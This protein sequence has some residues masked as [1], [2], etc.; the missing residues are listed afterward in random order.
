MILG[1]SVLLAVAGIGGFSADARRTLETRIRES[2]DAVESTGEVAG[3]VTFAGP[4][5]FFLQDG[6]EALKVVT[7][8]ELLPGVGTTVAVKGVAELE[9]ARVVLSAREWRTLA[10]AALPPPK[11][12]LAADLIDPAAA[13]SPSGVNWRRVEVEGRAVEL[14]ES[15]FGIDVGGV[16]VSVAL[17][18]LPDFLA[19][20]GVTRPLVRVRGVAELLLDQSALFGREAYVIGVRISAASPD[21][22]TLV[23]D[24]VYLANVRD[25]RLRWAFGVLLG[26]LAAGVVAFAVV[27]FRQRRRHF[28]TATLMAERK[29]MADDIHD[30]IEQHLVGAGM[31]I[32]LK[33]GKEAQDVLIRAKQELRDIIW[34]LKND[35]ML[36]LKPAE[37][38]AAAARSCAREGILEVDTRL[39]A[40][41]P[42]LG[43][44]ALRDL[45]L[46][47]REAIGNALK[48][49]GARRV[50][51]F[52]E[53]RAHGI[54]R[55]VVVNDGEVF[56]P[57]AAPGAEAGHFGLEGMRERARRLGARLTIREV[58]GR[59][60]VAVEGAG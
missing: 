31:L 43:A 56:D 7:D 32:Q 26:L 17:G 28:R 53:S 58:D 35:D 24:L 54:W 13:L 9:G 2:L 12:A 15:G 44:Q 49:G 45:A 33:R 34:G 10:P 48:H 3:T 27:I 8:A 42:R 25:R 11:S 22:V 36:R 14:T 18:T 37:L 5:R 39:A 40:L 41:P 38:I 4:G 1:L 21:D 46:I 20:C 6:D 29:R 50:E 51:V 60:E 19:D 16:P 23:P 30:T 55:L 59:M 52:A 47:V 57:S